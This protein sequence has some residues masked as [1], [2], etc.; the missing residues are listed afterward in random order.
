VKD[1]GSDPLFGLTN[2]TSDGVEGFLRQEPG[3]W[4]AGDALFQVAVTATARTRR[5]DTGQSPH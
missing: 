1:V 5:T 4:H 2:L 3:L